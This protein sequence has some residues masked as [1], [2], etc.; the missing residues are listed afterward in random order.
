MEVTIEITTYCG[1]DCDYCSTGAS[2]NGKHIPYSDIYDFLQKCPTIKRINISGGE[3]LSHPEFYKILKL[4][5]QYTNE[6]WVYTND[7]KNIRYN[8]DVVKEI[9]V[10]ANVCIIPGRSVY[11]PKTADKIHLLQ[12]TKSGRAK[13]MEPTKLK[14]SSNIEKD[15]CN[16]CNHIL[17]QAD[18]NV[19]NSPCVKCYKE[20]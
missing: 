15:N 20:R 13:N 14:A 18:G 1:N 5:D 16:T 12:L 3:P 10:E 17:L 19:V 4:C 2:I 9:R 8:S 6:V 11:I 7:I